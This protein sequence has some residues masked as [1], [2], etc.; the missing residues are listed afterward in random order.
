VKRV[1]LVFILIFF[2]IC[3]QSIA[4]ALTLGPYTG[5]AIDSQTGELIEDASVL[6]YW[7]KRVFALPHGYSELIKAELVYTNKA[8]KYNIGLSLANIR[9]S[10]ALESTN[11]II[12]KPG[13]QVYIVRIWHDNPYS[14]PNPIFKEKN[15]TVK[16]ERIP[17]NFNHK[18]H[19]RKI[20]DALSGIK[21][22][23]YSYPPESAIWVTWNKI[24]EIKLKALV[25]DELLSRAEWEKI[26]GELEDRR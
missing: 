7:E 6:F 15:N 10:S 22:Y 9:L 14:K 18:E 25:K 16:L 21:D 12:Y 13:Y 17:P 5:Q 3:L 1:I 8:G 19:Y 4:N 23:T 11:I 24:I 26:R 2:V 20:E